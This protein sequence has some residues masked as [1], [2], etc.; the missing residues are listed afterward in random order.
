MKKICSIMML[1]LL[2]LLLPFA[3]S[4]QN[5]YTLTVTTNDAAHTVCQINNSP[6]TLTDG[7]NTFDGLTQWTP[8]TLMP[9]DGWIMKEVLNV[10]GGY[11]NSEWN[12]GTDY[13]YIQSDLELKVEVA[14]LEEV[15]TTSFTINVDNPEKVSCYFNKT[16]Y[17]PELVAGENIVKCI[18]DVETPV[19]IGSN[20]NQYPLYSVS[21][22]GTPLSSSDNMYA[23]AV[24]DGMKVDITADYPDIDEAVNFVFLNDARDFVTKV[25]V[26]NEEVTNYAED[27]FKVKCGDRITIYGDE[28]NFV[29][30]NLSFKGEK[31]SQTDTYFYTSVSYT[32]LEPTTVTVNAEKAA[33]INVTVNVDNADAITLYRGYKYLNKTVPLVNGEN[34]ITFS[35]LSNDITIS[36]NSGFKIESITADGVAVEKGYYGDYELK[37]TEGLVINITSSEIVHDKTLVVY[38]QNLSAA[39]Y[40]VSF[41]ND[42]SQSYNLQE[43]YNVIQYAQEETPF[44]FS[45][46]YAVKN[47]Y[48][49]DEKMQVSNSFSI[50][51]E[52]NNSVLKIYLSVVPAEYTVEFTV[53]DDAPGFAVVRDIVRT[54]ETSQP[55]TV[56]SNTRFDIT[57]ELAD[58]LVVKV[59]DEPVAYDT[60]NGRYQFAINSDSKVEITRN[61]LVGVEITTADNAAKKIYN[62]QGVEINKNVSELPAGIYII[63]GKKV[64]R[65]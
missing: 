1:G 38:L 37:A 52:E 33:E 24:V 50:P 19:R 39:Y 4:A 48:L 45:E 35:N 2:A 16:Y 55:V 47:V 40:G 15:R 41:S 6:V 3:V 34:K 53:A 25:T 12:S 17:N 43:G 36:S 58:A 61:P 57:P 64:V 46:Y 31:Y 26:N 62:L 22:D 23:I 20:N 14:N 18:P 8:V 11:T 28:D 21:L 42:Y 13:N 9:A 60:E 27:G 59:N 10:T 49:N 51:V 29:F 54:V 7:T 5:T 65:K 56:L 30:N 44:Y 63:D 32:V